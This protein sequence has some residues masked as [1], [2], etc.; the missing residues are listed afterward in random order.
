MKGFILGFIL[1]ALTIYLV[2][3][4]PHTTA[5]VIGDGINAV[6]TAAASARADDNRTPDTT[7]RP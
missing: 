6:G 1:G 2:A 3:V 5:N 4:K 7:R